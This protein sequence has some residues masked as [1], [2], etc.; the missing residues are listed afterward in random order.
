M[1]EAEP[2]DQYSLSHGIC[3]ACE[4]THLFEA[5]NISDDSIAARQLLNSLLGSFAKGNLINV[6]S[7][8]RKADALNLRRTE[9][10]MG[11]LQPALYQ[12]G[13]QW[14]T[15]L[16]SVSQEHL[17]TSWCEGVFSLLSEDLSQAANPAILLTSFPANLH[18]LGIRFLGVHLRDLGYSCRVLHADMQ[19]NELIKLC[20]R[21]NISVCGIS[22]SMT[23]GYAS[24]T[25]LARQ[26]NEK[27]EG[28]TQAVLGGF[29]F[30]MSGRIH[31]Q[32]VPVFKK[33]DDFAEF[34][35]EVNK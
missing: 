32:G 22:V 1:G 6:K 35:N 26:I 31:S 19:E 3:E 21:D 28:R 10:I 12:I 15:G 25:H 29:A 30:R 23:D 13:E 33:I 18:T 14:K 9:I 11:L 2:L 7:F 16:I 5:S 8:I 17:F 34:L 24:A 4:Q 20:L 27:T